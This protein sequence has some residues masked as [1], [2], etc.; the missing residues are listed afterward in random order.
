MNSENDQETLIPKKSV[1]LILIL[2]GLII[3]F[4]G[5]ATYFVYFKQPATNSTKNSSEI[6]SLNDFVSS[7]PELLPAEEAEKIGLGNKTLDIPLKIKD[8]KVKITMVP[9]MLVGGDA[10]YEAVAETNK[11]FFIVNDDNRKDLFSIETEKDALN[12]IDF[13]MSK[14]GKSSYDRA[15]TTIWTESDYSEVGCKSAATG[16][17]FD[18]P[19]EKP[20]SR[21]EKN[22]NGFTVDWIYSTIAFP[23]G[24][25]A[26]R[27]WVDGQ[28]GIKTLIKAEKP[29]WS[30]GQ[31]VM[32]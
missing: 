7:Q 17:N 8:K 12:Y 24:F 5:A 4:L 25:Y 15:R 6:K 2:M 29:F 27:Y 19:K 14:A 3:L 26:E 21:A 22:D 28:G 31:G 1:S 30:C 18:L 11:G 32:F 16:E 23:A 13:L 10:V 9:K 20:I